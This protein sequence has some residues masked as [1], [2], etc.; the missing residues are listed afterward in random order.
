MQSGELEPR[1]DRFERATALDP[2]NSLAYN[3]WMRTLLLAGQGDD[4]REVLAQARTALPDDPGSRSSQPVWPGNAPSGAISAELQAAL[5][6][7]QA[8]L[9]R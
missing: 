8:A 7:G 9:E 6:A 2:A 5:D 4:A 1:L 3:L